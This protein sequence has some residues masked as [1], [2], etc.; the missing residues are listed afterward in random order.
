MSDVDILHAMGQASRDSSDPTHESVVRIIGRRH[1]KVAYRRSQAD[2]QT[3]DDPATVIKVACEE[4]FG[5]GVILQ[6]APPQSGALPEFPVQ[7]GEQVTSSLIESGTLRTIPV[8][9]VDYLLADPNLRDDV[10]KWINENK[11]RI[12]AQAPEVDEA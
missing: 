1:F 5:Q 11:A 3:H 2:L 12:L 7:I 6:S 8:A 9:S 4:Q 10:Q